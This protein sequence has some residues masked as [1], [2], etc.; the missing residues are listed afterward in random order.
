M[1]EQ[2]VITDVTLCSY[3]I[4]FGAVYSHPRTKHNTQR[5]NVFWRY[6]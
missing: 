3:N 4:S 2:F 5:L 6:A 1:R